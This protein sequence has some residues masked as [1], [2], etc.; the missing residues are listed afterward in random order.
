MLVSDQVSIKLPTG[1]TPDQISALVVANTGTPLVLIKAQA[2]PVPGPG[3]AG[4]AASPAPPS[5]REFWLGLI[6]VIKT[7][8]DAVLPIVLPAFGGATA[9]LLDVGIEDAEAA[10]LGT[11]TTEHWT[12]DMLKAKQ[13]GVQDPKT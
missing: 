5:H 2:T 6:G 9:H 10:I 7:A 8:A 13:A 4:A 3:I 11:P 12:L 1:F